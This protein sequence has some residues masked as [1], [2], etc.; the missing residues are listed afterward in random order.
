[1]RGDR[2]DLLARCVEDIF[3]LLRRGR[4]VE[5]EN[6]VPR[7]AQRLQR[8]DD[9]ILAALAE[10]LDR[11]I[12]RDQILL[13]ETAAKIE[14]D[15]R[16]G[17]E[18]DF[19]FL[20]TD[21]DEHFEIFEL[22]LHAHG[23]RERLVAVAKIYA[24]P[25][26][27]GAQ[28]AVRPLAVRKIDLR[29]GP[30]FGDRRL[31]HGVLHSSTAKVGA[32]S[33]QKK[34]PGNIHHHRSRI[35]TAGGCDRLANEGQCGLAG[36]IA[37]DFFDATIEESIGHTIRA[38][39]EAVAWL[40]SHGSGLGFDLLRVRA[41]DFLQDISPGM[42]F[43]LALVDLAISKKPAD[44]GVIVGDLFHTACRRQEVNATIANMGEIHPARCEPTKAQRGT[45][46][47]AFV[48]TG[49]EI[50]K[51]SMDFDKDLLKHIAES[52][53]NARS[54][55]REDGRQEFRDF[56]YGDLARKLASH[57]PAHPVAHREHKIGFSDFRIAGLSEQLDALRIN[58]Q[59]EERVLVVF[60]NFPAV[61]MPRPYEAFYQGGTFTHSSDS[62]MVA[63]SKSMRQKRPS[64]WR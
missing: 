56:F 40:E 46:A 18:A 44:I 1:M 30:V 34:L 60:S 39:Q 42:V 48:I 22:F 10:D 25:N 33:F 12:M 13:D 58:E 47:S 19:D 7:P 9:E 63:N 62:K 2:Y 59:A 16:S 61:G 8:A 15:L 57:C 64:D 35:V 37:Q 43:R 21:A 32:P 11:D 41:E 20:E 49:T 55:L 3:T 6:D 45:H 50:E 51:R 28:S 36:G 4:V 31:L 26:G 23:L 38:E 24:T 53:G 27:S 54:S 29:K 17:W 14:F 52:V 5:V